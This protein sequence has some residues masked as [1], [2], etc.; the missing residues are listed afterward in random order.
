M[1]S[2]EKTRYWKVLCNDGTDGCE[3][4]RGRYA[5]ASPYQAANKALT[6]IIRRRKTEGKK[7]TGKIS[8]TMVE[9]TR[10]SKKREHHYE[11]R[12]VKL[13]EP[14]KYRAGDQELVKHYKNQLKKLTKA[15]LK[16]KK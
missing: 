16:N 11:G 10:G 14:I 9:S 8:L 2:S 3:A 12:R 13:K 4:P 6:E 7:T 5:G 15:D 1:S